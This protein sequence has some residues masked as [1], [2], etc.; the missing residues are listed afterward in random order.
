VSP[1]TYDDTQRGGHAGTVRI[2]ARRVRSRIFKFVP[3]S[4]G[5]HGSYGPF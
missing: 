4:A 2:P 1:G 5:Q 3:A